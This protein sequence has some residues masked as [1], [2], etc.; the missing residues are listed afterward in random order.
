MFVE[1]LPALPQDLRPFSPGPPASDRAA[2]EGLESSLRA[3]LIADGE[4]ALDAAFPV[5][6]ASGYLEFTRSGDRAGFEAGYFGRRRL[7]NALVLAE[8]AEY[9]GRFL[10]R[11]VDGV[12]LLCEESGWQLPAHNSQTPGGP[13]SGLPDVARPIIDLFAAET[14][15]QL[16]VAAALLGAELDAAAPGSMRRLDME[17]ERRIFVP[18]L[19]RHFWWMGGGEARTN[20][21]TA[22]CTQN[23]LL[24]AGARPSGEE[25]RRRVLVRAAR[26]LDAFVR[27]YGEDGACEEG[28]LYYR[29][30][31]LCLFNSL[32]VLAEV[33]PEVFAPLWRE[34][35]LRRI[36]EFI[37][38]MHVSGQH[39]FNFADSSAVL[40]PCGAREYLFGQAVGSTALAD[41]AAADWEA[42]GRSTQP[43]EINLFYRLQAVFGAAAMAGHAGTARPTPD[44]FL[45]SI[46][47]MTAR[48]GRFAL[49]VKAGHNGES[50]NHNDVGSVTLYKDGRPLLIDVGVETYSARTFSAARYDIWTMQS[51]YHNLPGFGGVMQSAGRAFSARDVSVA[52]D[53]ERAVMAMD[54]AGAYPAAASVR[55]Y[56]RQVVLEKG[57]GV[58]ITDEH[59][60]DRSA[61]LSLMLAIA[62]QLGDGKITLPG[63]AEITI[64]GAGALRCETI[65]VEDARL[66]RAW[67]D[68]LY[69]VLVP[70]SGARLRLRIA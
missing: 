52:L 2:W 45:E 31:G 53:A 50:H 58:E 38:P 59:D 15:A 40:E 3:Q 70:L 42:A 14:G 67:P 16:A 24:A 1:R 69:R 17:L 20:N 56:R 64:E 68:R 55:S 35:K 33:A 51:G 46:G 44:R 29:H 47:V 5:L 66:R 39:Y 43:D 48:D 49:A 65:E 37:L 32:M 11:I 54:I 6:T 30:A 63:L 36:A 57:K 19:T 25:Q 60:G 8:C 12:L 22:W 9:R 10:D 26:S 28:V 23:I 41:F 4:A 61:E 21:W 34:P 27:D 13:R 18:Y 7:L 62:P